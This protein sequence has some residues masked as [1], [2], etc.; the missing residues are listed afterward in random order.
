MSN[1]PSGYQPALRGYAA[2][3]RASRQSFQQQ[4][5]QQHSQR[6]P[7]QPGAPGPYGPPRPPPHRQQTPTRPPHMPQ[8]RSSLHHTA[9]RPEDARR[10]R[11]YLNQ[12][13]RQ[14]TRT[15]PIAGGR[16]PHQYNQ[17]HHQQ[18]TEGGEYGRGPYRR[19]SVSRSRSLSRPER[20]R[21]KQGMI[22]SPSQNRAAIGVRP[23]PGAAHPSMYGG[24]RPYYNQPMSSHLQ[25][26]LQ[27]QKLQQQ[28][29]A[30]LDAPIPKE[31]A[32]EEP[33]P[34]PKVL[35]S[36]WAWTAFLLT[37]CIPNWFIRVVLRKPNPLMQQAWREKV[38]YVVTR[39]IYCCYLLTVNAYIPA[40]SCIHYL[41]SMWCVGIYY[42]WS[43]YHAVSRVPP[44]LPLLNSSGWRPSSHVS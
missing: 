42:L 17:Y 19:V 27:Q 34:K 21:P 31:S 6:L 9:S 20:Q 37:C 28:Q 15:P 29:A 36:W 38:Y 2:D 24:Q 39:K 16:N 7:Q 23:Y 26:Q 1:Y 3:A 35:T 14:P 44:K 8:Q 32:P 10:S 12:P 25:Q 13:Q 41:L 5:Q 30:G 43:Q 4:Q 18:H 22:R 40:Y 33:E 11:E